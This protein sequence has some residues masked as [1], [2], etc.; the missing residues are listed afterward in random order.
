MLLVS[1]CT[2]VRPI[3]AMPILGDCF[4]YGTGVG[5]DMAKGVELYSRAAEV[6]DAGSI[7]C[8]DLF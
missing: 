7:R 6:S 5:E 8:W 2:S 3:Q 4:L 1:K